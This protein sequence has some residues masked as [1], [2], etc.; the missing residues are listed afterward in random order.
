MSG[1][2]FGVGLVWLVFYLCFW[3]RV[4]IRSP[5]W[6]LVDTQ[7][8]PAPFW[9]KIEDWIGGGERRGGGGGERGKEGEESAIRMQNKSIIKRNNRKRGPGRP[10]NRHQHPGTGT[11]M[12]AP[13]TGC[14][15]EAQQSRVLLRQSTGLGQL[16]ASYNSRSRESQLIPTYRNTHLHII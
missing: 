3:E 13:H 11:K 15:R 9:T 14:G 6:C 10:Y 2:Q 7:G 5:G 12:C 1:L 8:R 4:S 16:T